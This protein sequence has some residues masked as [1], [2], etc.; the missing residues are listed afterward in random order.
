M[1][2]VATIL[3][4]V[5]PFT[6]ELSNLLFFDGRGTTVR[7]VTLPV[8]FAVTIA[9]VTGDGLP[10]PFLGASEVNAFSAARTRNLWPLISAARS[11]DASSHLLAADVDC[12]GLRDFVLFE[13]SRLLQVRQSG[14]PLTLVELDYTAEELNDQVGAS[15][16]NPTSLRWLTPT[17]RFSRQAGQAC[18]LLAIPEPSKEHIEIYGPRQSG[19]APGTFERLSSVRVS[20]TSFDH[21]LFVDMNDDGHD[22]LLLA[23]FTGSRVGYGL[24]DGTFHSD[25]EQLPAAF[26]GKA[27]NETSEYPYAGRLLTAGAQ[28]DQPPLFVDADAGYVDAK[29]A[30]LT[31]DGQLDAVAINSTGRVDVLRGLPDGRLSALPIPGSNLR[32]IEDIADFDGDGLGDVLFSAQ[33]NVDKPPSTISLLFSPVTSGSSARQ[34]AFPGPLRELTAGYV[35]DATGA[36]DTNA[37]IGVLYRGSDDGTRLGFLLG[38]SDQLLRSRVGADRD[39]ELV[40][41]RTPALGHFDDPKEQ[42]LVIINQ[43]FAPDPLLRV[44]LFSVDAEGTKLVDQTDLDIHPDLAT[45]SI[46]LEAIDQDGD[47][48]DE[49]YLDSANELVA[50]RRVAGRFETKRADSELWDPLTRD[51]INGDG[52]PDLSTLSRD[53]G[54][55]AKVKVLL[56]AAPDGTPGAFHTFEVEASLCATVLDRVFIQADDDEQRELAV[57]CGASQEVGVGA[58][59]DSAPKLEDGSL[60]IFDIDWQSDTLSPKGFPQATNLALSLVVGD[61]NGDGVQDFA[62]GVGQPQLWLGQARR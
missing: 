50:L 52:R 56:G 3:L 12:D 21:A 39:D 19:G 5:Q 32:H 17:G 26:S 30:N 11:V 59:T 53:D 23:S 29:V 22:D 15:P 44:D 36:F 2:T 41:L 24:G 16:E 13:G 7:Q 47:G 35:G 14:D 55:G 54:G 58:A 57:I 28:P 43:V 45:L 31:S 27:D 42:Q 8:A 37:D 33:S 48:L 20:D 9:D 25:P 62:T 34:L 1:A 38:G 40:G 10:D 60:L 61:F 46:N 4:S 6:E 18:E 49:L 51:D